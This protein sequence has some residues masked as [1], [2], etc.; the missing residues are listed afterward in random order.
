[1]INKINLGFTPPAQLTVG[2]TEKRFWAI[3]FDDLDRTSGDP[4]TY[5]GDERVLSINLLA[6][7][8]AY[9]IT[10]FRTD[11]K[12]SDEVITPG[13]G[14]N[15]LKHMASFVIASRTQ[16]QKNSIEKYLR[17]KVVIVAVNLGTD[18]DAFE[19][20]GRQSGLE[21]VPGKIR[22]AHENGGYFTLSF[23]TLETEFETKLPQSV[24]ASYSDGLTIMT[25]LETA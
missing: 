23:A 1:M 18:A 10:G 20:L 2:G 6:G 25:A 12:K 9:S 5:D 7:K 11:L 17:A 22:D 4:F 24:G 8:V 16:E 15:Q 3:N 14:P 21:V 19:L 13:L